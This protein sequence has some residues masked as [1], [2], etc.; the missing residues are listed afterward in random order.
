MN[1][2]E[3]LPHKLIKDLPETYK[4]LKS[5]NLVVDEKIKAVFLSGSRGPANS[6][7]TNS[8]IDITMI[9]DNELINNPENCEEKLKQIIRYTIDNWIHEIELDTVLIYDNN[10]CDLKC[11]LEND[12]STC[13]CEKTDCFG[14]Y[15]IQK[16]FKGFVPKMGIDSREVFPIV[17]IW[18]R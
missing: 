10:H 13:K 5:G 6:F 8:D 11:F 12:I 15:K 3:N 9:L 1:I 18:K 16:G 2:S 17:M 14:L 4:I 7:K